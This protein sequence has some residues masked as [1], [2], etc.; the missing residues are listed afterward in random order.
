MRHLTITSLFA[1]LAIA[2]TPALAQLTPVPDPISDP[3]ASLIS[4]AVVESLIG[5]AAPS[6]E[7]TECDAVEAVPDEF[8][9]LAFIASSTEVDV[10]VTSTDGVIHDI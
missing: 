1:I 4:P 2:S 10:F 8:G 7:C 5:D 9:R 6:E 3:T